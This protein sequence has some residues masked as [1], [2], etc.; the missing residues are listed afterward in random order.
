MTKNKSKLA[1]SIIVLSLTLSFTAV[2]MARSTGSRSRAIGLESGQDG[3]VYTIKEAGL[4]F[5]VPKSWKVEV[6]KESSNIVLSIEE[7]AVTITLMPEDNFAQVVAGMK[8]GLKDKLPDLK[9]DGEPKEDTHNGMVHIAETGTGSI[10][11]VPVVWSIDVLKATKP[12]TILT[13]GI[14]KTIETHGEEFQNFVN[15]LKKA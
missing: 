3:G 12:V 8:S 1:R 10:N 4:Q 7:G 6:E 15:S 5:Q 13:F 11:N 14:R 9:S 2:T